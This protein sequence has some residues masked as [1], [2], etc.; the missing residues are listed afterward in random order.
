MADFVVSLKKEIKDAPTV[1]ESRHAKKKGP[2]QKKKGG[3]KRQ[4]HIY[5][6]LLEHTNKT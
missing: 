1:Q 6:P 2:P 5:E 3:R 4:I